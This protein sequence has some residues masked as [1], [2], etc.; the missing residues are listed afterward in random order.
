MKC[1]RCGIEMNLYSE[2][3]SFVCPICEMTYI[4]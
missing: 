1:H 3:V 2:P 4:E